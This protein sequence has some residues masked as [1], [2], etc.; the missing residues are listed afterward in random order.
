MRLWAS[1]FP[2]VGTQAQLWCHFWAANRRLSRSPFRLIW[3]PFQKSHTVIPGA[4]D[5]SYFMVSFLQRLSVL[6]FF[7]YFMVSFLQQLSVPAFKGFGTWRCSPGAWCCSPLA[8]SFCFCS[9]FSIW[10]IS[11]TPRLFFSSP[12]PLYPYSQSYL[13]HRLC[14]PVKPK[15]RL[16]QGCCALGALP[17]IGPHGPKALLRCLHISP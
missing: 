2:F 8:R 14:S 15:L 1:L 7:R 16:F 9:H 6:A 5:L 13:G 17:W 3:G 11:R 10:Q 4:V 12:P